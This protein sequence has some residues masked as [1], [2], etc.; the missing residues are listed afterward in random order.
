MGDFF[1]LL[2]GGSQS[3]LTA[4]IVNFIISGLKGGA[5]VL[6]GNVAMF[7]EM[8][9]SLGDAANQFFVFIGSALSKKAPTDRFPFGFG[10][11]VN[12]VCLGA[13]II[14]AILS[15][16]TVKEGIHHIMYPGHGAMSTRNLLINLGVLGL[17]VIL[18]VG[19]LYKAGK[20]VLQETNNNYK[21]LAPLTS[22]F[23]HSKNA[24]PATKLVF[25]E[26]TVAT[27]GGILAM[28][29]ILISQFTPF[30]VAEGI[31]S[32]I[33][34]LMMFYVVYKIFMENAAGVLGEHAPEMEI[35]VSQILFSNE[36]IKDIQ[37]LF[38]LKE[39]EDLHVE[40]T[41][42]L[43]HHLTLKEVDDIR[44]QLT[45]II[46]QQHHVTDVNIEFKDN[47]GVQAWPERADDMD[48]RMP[49]QNGIFK[50]H[51]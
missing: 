20:E 37:R 45:D 21:G 6:T 26:D 51:N 13:V 49:G 14:V 3:S 18:E 28:I 17:G 39:G 2:K 41:V 30:N 15:Y 38:V 31:A 8:M 44:E 25:M 11:L 32:V 34:G 22:A 5:F 48:H 33:I 27:V 1:K 42:E 7:A 40:A 4:A 47:D 29:A 50:H 9:H 10:R 36:H 23:V 46:L 24:K 12:L 35:R 16:E 43:N 19:V